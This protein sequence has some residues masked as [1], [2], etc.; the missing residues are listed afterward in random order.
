MCGGGVPC[1]SGGVW[2]SSLGVWEKPTL[3]FR[4]QRLIEEPGGMQAFAA[5]K[6]PL[7]GPFLELVDLGVAPHAVVS[8]SA[9]VHHCCLL[10]AVLQYMCFVITAF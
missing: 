10:H 4:P 2:S 6:V 9:M 8:A 3:S 7:P 1:P 5:L